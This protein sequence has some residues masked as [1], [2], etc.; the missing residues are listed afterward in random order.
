MEPCSEIPLGVPT[1]PWCELGLAPAVGQ[2][3]L[4]GASSPSNW[5][6]CGKMQLGLGK[7]EMIKTVKGSWQ[8][9]DSKQK[10][11]VMFIVKEK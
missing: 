11:S 8:P 10:R 7:Q 5:L 6:L 4:Q 2:C 9:F 3:G 1:A